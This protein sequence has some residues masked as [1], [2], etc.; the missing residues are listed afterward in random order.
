MQPIGQKAT[1]VELMGQS[2]PRQ[3]LQVVTREH[4]TKLT[5]LIALPVPDSFSCPCSAVGSQ[6]GGGNEAHPGHATEPPIEL[7]YISLSPHAV[8]FAHFC[9]EG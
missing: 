7:T 1:V 6:T 8:C 2:E 9:G 5:S 4:S 3:S